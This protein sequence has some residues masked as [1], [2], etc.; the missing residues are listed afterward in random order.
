MRSLDSL[1]L[2]PRAFAGIR[3]KAKQ[4]ERKFLKRSIEVAKRWNNLEFWKEEI[5]RKTGKGRRRTEKKVQRGNG[6]NEE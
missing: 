3:L 6:E 5:K 1:K 2:N 4:R